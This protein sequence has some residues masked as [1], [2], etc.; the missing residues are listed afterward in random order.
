MSLFPS[1]VLPLIPGL[2]LAAGA[3]VR[4]APG[5]MAARA[6]GAAAT[7]AAALAAIAAGA[8]LWSRAIAA[9]SPP[10]FVGPSFSALRLDAVAAAMTLLV[11]FLGMVV[12]RFSRRYLAGEPG[13]A[14]FHAWM[15][16]T[17]GTV[18]I[19]VLAGNLLVL[20]AA[21]VATSLSLHQLLTFYPDRSDGRFAARK[22]FIFSRLGDACLV[23]G[24]LMLYRHYGSFELDVIFAAAADGDRS[25]LPAAAFLFAGCAMLKSAQFPFHSW[26]P[27]TMDTPTPVSAFMHAGIVN[28]GGFLVIRLQPVFA[29][30]AGASAMLAVTGAVTAAYG[31]VVMLTQPSV[32]RALAYSTIAQMGFMLMQCGLG[33]YGLALLHIVG[34]SLYKAHAFL[35]SGSTVGAVPRAAVPLRPGALWAGLAT[36]A[37]IVAAA[38][39]LAGSHLAASPGQGVGVLVL[40][41]AIA[42]GLARYWSAAREPLAAAVAA[43]AAFAFAC[44][45]L[46]LETGATHLFED[47]RPPPP[48]PVLLAAVAALFAGL[49]LFQAVLWRADRHPVGRKIYVHALNGFYVGTLFNRALGRLWPKAG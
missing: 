19:L 22:K 24:T 6:S 45:G 32:K 30:A 25:V 37:I 16:F 26:L 46:M 15:S 34:H 43:P 42:Y 40:F 49:F 28:A 21:W 33:A 14:P 7:A 4:A 10:G 23:G 44:L 2:P 8:F 39:R 27:D 5:R 38:L 36:A 12:L 20:A 13:E 31:A 41:F 48:S 18:L 11:S 47:T 3:L 9:W 17:L 35:R 29:A 1:V